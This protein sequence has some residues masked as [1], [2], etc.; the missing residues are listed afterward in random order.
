[1][2]SFFV[3]LLFLILFANSSFALIPSKVQIKTFFNN[4][5][6]RIDSNN[7]LLGKFENEISLRGSDNES[8]YNIAA[9]LSSRA[10]S[11]L[12]TEFIMTAIEPELQ[13]DLGYYD[14]DI[15]E[16]R[17]KLLIDTRKISSELFADSEKVQKIINSYIEELRSK[18]NVNFKKNEIFAN[19]LLN[20]F[21]LIVSKEWGN[22]FLS[23]C[24]LGAIDALNFIY[25]LEDVIEKQ[26]YGDYSIIDKQILGHL[27]WMKE[28]TLFHV[29]IAIEKKVIML[30]DLH[31]PDGLG[32]NDFKSS[33]TLLVAAFKE[34]H[35]Y[36]WSD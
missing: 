19:K 23:N 31:L 26:R 22:N 5:D 36:I 14:E 34:I 1:M 9:K 25:R 15:V 4:I 32:E 12:Y 18:G 35:N 16:Y 28:N 33:N 20:E 2:R 7:K 10:M 13:I 17:V 24:S 29:P 8:Y 27:D 6:T 21:S 30:Q 3:P 11:M